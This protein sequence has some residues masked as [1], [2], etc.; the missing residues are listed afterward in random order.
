[1][2][3]TD[4]PTPKLDEELYRTVF[5]SST[6]LNLISQPY[7]IKNLFEVARA[8]QEQIAILQRRLSHIEASDR[9]Y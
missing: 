4:D 8:Q 3:C 5:P 6:T 2:K 1:M 9:H 7:L